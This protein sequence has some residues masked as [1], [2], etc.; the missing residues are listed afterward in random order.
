MA[1]PQQVLILEPNN[2]LAFKGKNIIITKITRII[3]YFFY[4]P[5]HKLRQCKP[6]TFQSFTK[7]RLF[8]SEGYKFKFCT[9]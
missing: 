6:N 1:K 7:R 5:I 4:R 9:I 3:N 8:Q 2:E